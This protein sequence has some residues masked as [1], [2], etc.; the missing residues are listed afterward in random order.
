MLGGFLG[1]SSCLAAKRCQSWGPVF[2]FRGGHGGPETPSQR[3]ATLPA[4]PQLVTRIAQLRNA[5]V[6]SAWFWS[7]PLWNTRNDRGTRH[8][9]CEDSARQSA[10]GCC[11]PWRACAQSGTIGHCMRDSDELAT[12]DAWLNGRFCRRRPAKDACMPRIIQQLL[13]L[14]APFPATMQMVQHL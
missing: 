5:A 13:P 6:P 12:S 9:S 4:P 14:F 1:C 10:S 3:H 2:P 8:R 11:F 7:V